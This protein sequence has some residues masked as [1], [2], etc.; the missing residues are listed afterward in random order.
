MEILSQIEVLQ[1][2]CK[3][4]QKWGMFISIWEP[5]Q[6]P[7]EAEK[8]APYLSEMEHMQIIHDGIGFLLFDTE[9]EMQKHFNLT[10]G[11]DGPTK[12][13]SYNG[14][15]C[16]YALTCNQDGQLISENT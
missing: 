12:L 9:E 4:T 7:Y 2:L 1:R 5:K 15:T 6:G 14:K 8:A 3:N 16:V 11:D 13:N 10:V